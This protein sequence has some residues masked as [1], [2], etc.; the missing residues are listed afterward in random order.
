MRR[1]AFTYES[2]PESYVL[3]SIATG[4]ASLGRQSKGISQRENPGSD[5]GLMLRVDN[6]YHIKTITPPKLKRNEPELSIFGNINIKGKPG[7]VMKATVLAE[8]SGN[9]FHRDL[10][11]PV[12]STDSS[13]VGVALF[14][15][16]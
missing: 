11:A 7:K 1:V 2:D 13:Q 6:L 3:D 5:R 14:P 9:H 15:S 10:S 16:F 12:M 4:R 8:K